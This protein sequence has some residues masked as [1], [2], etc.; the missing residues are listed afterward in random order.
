MVESPAT[1]KL[2][3]VTLDIIPVI[4]FEAVATTTLALLI[5]LDF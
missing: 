2:W 5:G 1:T 4:L 3:L